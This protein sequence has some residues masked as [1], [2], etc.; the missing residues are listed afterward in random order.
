MLHRVL[1]LPNDRLRVKSRELSAAEIA[2]SDIQNLIIE[3]KA[4][5]KQENGVGL[6]APQ[7]G[8][9]IRLIIAQTLNGNEAFINPKIISTSN[10]LVDSEEGCLSIPGV[11]GLV[12]R[13]RGVTVQAINAAGEHIEVKATGL[14]AIIF[15]HEIDHLDGILFI[16][17][18]YTLKEPSTVGG[19][20]V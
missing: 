7:I 4:T 18:A 14:L 19:N 8:Q 9:P 1:T 3:M 12:K 11:W 6:A 15:Q 16:D 5:M 17:R 2:S 13:H 10:R 20:V